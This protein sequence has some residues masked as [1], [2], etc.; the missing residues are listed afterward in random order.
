MSDKLETLSSKI[1]EVLGRLEQLKSENA[2]LKD[3]DSDLKS[4]LVSVRKQYNSVVLE[5]ADQADTF[6][7]KLVLVL[8]RLNQLESL[9]E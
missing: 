8:N 2:S 9:I 1:D 7:D 5:K 6:R 3:Q 4:E